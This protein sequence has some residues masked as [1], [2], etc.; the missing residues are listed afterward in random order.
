MDTTLIKFTPVNVDQRKKLDLRSGDTIRIWSKIE[1]KGKTRL[2]AFEG[3]VLARKHGTETGASITIRKS[4]AGGIGVER[5]FPLYSPNIDKIE[6]IKRAKTRRSKLYY[7]RKKAAKEIRRKMRAL[8]SFKYV[9]MV[10]VKEEKK[11][12]G[13]E[14]V[15]EKEVQDNKVEEKKT[16]EKSVPK[17]NKKKED[18]IEKDKSKEENKVEEKK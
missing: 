18:V 4:A 17:E 9:E 12:D 10:E 16:E 13:N 7:I 14:E 3:L 8:T 6:I 1:E 15:Q 5:I 11:D 2:Q